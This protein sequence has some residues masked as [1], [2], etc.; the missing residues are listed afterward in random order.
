M[1]HGPRF[2][3]LLQKTLTLMFIYVSLHMGHNYLEDYP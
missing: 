2:F 1:V 3:P